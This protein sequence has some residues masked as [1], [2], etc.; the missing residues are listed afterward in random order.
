MIKIEEWKWKYRHSITI[1]FEDNKYYYIVIFN[2]T[3]DVTLTELNKG[4][5]AVEDKWQFIFIS[6]IILL[7]Q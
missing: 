7:N 4:L 5:N 6:H 3:K 2:N 1:K